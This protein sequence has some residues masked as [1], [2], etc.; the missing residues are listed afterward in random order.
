MTELVMEARGLVKRYGQVVALDGEVFCEYGLNLARM[1]QPAPVIVL[2]Y[3]N[4]VAA[5][6]PTA[7]AIRDGGYEPNAFR[8][9][10]LP[11]P[12][13]PECESLVLQSAAALARPK[14]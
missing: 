2:G 12:Y 10:Q 8:W 7:K 3:S 5:Y 14:P 11:G 1:L 9:W 13:R 4:G 6:L